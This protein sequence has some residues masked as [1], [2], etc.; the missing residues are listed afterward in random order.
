MHK[1]YSVQIE[2]TKGCNFSC[3]FCGTSSFPKGL[4]EFMTIETGIAVFKQLAKFGALRIEFAMRGE[5]TLNPNWLDF[6]ALCRKICNKSSITLLTNG[7]KLTAENIIDF[8]VLGG[9]CLGIDC[10]NN[11]IDKFKNLCKDL[12]FNQFE[13]TDI[14][15]PWQRHKLKT[16]N[17]VFIKE[18]EF[19]NKKTAKRT[20]TNQCGAVSKKAIKKYNIETPPEDGFKSM[21]VHPFRDM[22]VYYNGKT[23]ICCRDYLEEKILFDF[24]DSTTSVLEYWYKNKELNFI[25]KKLLQKERNFLPCNKCNFHG[26]FR[27]GLEY[28]FFKKE[29]KL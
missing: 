14:Y 6:I 7:S 4:R 29:N 15:N 17:I 20:Y 13:N 1:P 9:N 18:E 16:Q 8:F 26:G 28:N 24:L 27:K 10:Y 21:C 5:P 23:S 3:D 2:L 22:A 11:S 12:P 19:T 25:R